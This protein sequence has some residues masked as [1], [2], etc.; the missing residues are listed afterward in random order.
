MSVKKI[1]LALSLGIAVI[2]PVKSS[3]GLCN[4]EGGAGACN[5]TGRGANKLLCGR[6]SLSFSAAVIPVGH[7]AGSGVITSDCHGNLIDGFETINDDGQVCQGTLAGTYSLERNGTGTVSF[8]LIPPNPSVSCPIVNFSEA[9]AVGQGGSIVKAVNTDSD[10]VTI[11]EEW[12]R[13]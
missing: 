12:V 6:Y 8:S 9:I 1:A 13:Q 7:I 2:Y 11:Q 5:G 4:P 10:E 3:F